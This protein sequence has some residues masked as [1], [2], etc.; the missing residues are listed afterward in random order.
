[1]FLLLLAICFLNTHVSQTALSKHQTIN[2]DKWQAFYNA[3]SPPPSIP[4][5]AALSAVDRTL[6]LHPDLDKAAAGY[7]FPDPGMLAAF[8]RDKRARAVTLWLAI[9]CARAS[10]LLKPGYK[11]PSP[12]SASGWRDFF[13]IAHR[14]KFNPA[15][16]TSG[17]P[18]NEQGLL[19]K[20]MRSAIIMFGESDAAQ[21]DVNVS[22]IQ[23]F[24]ATYPV[25]DGLAVGVDEY[26]TA[27]ILWEL[28]E[29][30]WRSELLALDR[31]AAPAKWAEPDADILRKA[32][33]V[34]VFGPSGSFT[35]ASS[36]FP[37]ENLFICHSD[38]VLHT[39]ALE[40][41]RRL[42]VDWRAC[43]PALTTP[44]PSVRWSQDAG[45]GPHAY[46]NDL[47]EFAIPALE[48][49]RCAI[50]VFYCSSFYQFFGRPP[51]LPHLLPGS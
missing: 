41:L 43:P 23:L 7:M 45:A 42:M 36:S 1:M 31:V 5:F 33:I 9:R 2:R 49:Q 27:R 47:E 35:P 13:W 51:V 3:V 17:L 12:L 11:L 25:R 16:G 40:N 32:L 34:P 22:E 39:H 38:V 21:M 28:A 14:H 20:A 37:A 10:Q 8:E 50:K 26:V 4:W 46:L 6:P 30:N 48:R 24:G 15:Q 29:L 44:L 18:S 19:A